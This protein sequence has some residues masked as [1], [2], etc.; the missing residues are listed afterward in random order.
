MAEELTYEQAREQLQGVVA[1]LESGDVPLTDAM[2]LWE[3]GEELADT[4]D[5]WLAGAIEKV[6]A[7]KES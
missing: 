6:E 1:Q 7:K 2:K 5:K 3:R 4:C